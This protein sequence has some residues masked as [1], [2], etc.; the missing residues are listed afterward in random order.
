MGLLKDAVNAKATP[1]QRAALEALEYCRRPGWKRICDIPPDEFENIYLAFD[2]LDIHWRTKFIAAFGEEDAPI[3]YMTFGPRQ[4]RVPF[5]Y[6]LD[7]GQVIGSEQWYGMDL[8]GRGC[9]MILQV[10]EVQ[11]E[12]QEVALFEM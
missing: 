3:G 4:L 8:A 11:K 12:E 2:E 7:D 10:G 5:M 9:M 6:V 1:N